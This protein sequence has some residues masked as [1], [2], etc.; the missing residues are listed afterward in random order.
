MRYLFVIGIALLMGGT[1]FA[2]TGRDT[3]PD[4]VAKALENISA[5]CGSTGRNEACYGHFSLD[6]E[7]QPSASTFN[8]DAPGDIESVTAIRTLKLAGVDLSAGIWGVALM[9]LQANLPDTSPGQNVTVLLFGDVELTSNDTMMTGFYLQ[10]GIG[11]SACR[12]LPNSGIMVQTPKGSTKIALTVNDVLIELGS[13]VYIT[14][15]ESDKMSVYL[16][17]GEALVTAEG[18][19]VSLE[20][21]YY[22][23][24]LLGSSLTPSSVPRPA[25][26]YEAT[27]LESLSMIG[28]ALPRPLIE[29][30]DICTIE[31]SRSVNMRSGPSTA[32]DVIGALNTGSSYEV[33]HF[34]LLDGNKWWQVTGGG[35]V[36]A[37]LVTQTG[38]C[39]TVTSTIDYPPVPVDGVTDSVAEPDSSSTS[40]APSSSGGSSSVSGGGSAII[41]PWGCE[42][43][44]SEFTPGT[45]T[46]FYGAGGYDSC[47]EAQA[48][49]SGSLANF[50]GNGPA[51]FIYRES[52]CHFA[53][54]KWGITT[55]AE[56]EFL[57]GTYSYVADWIHGARTCSFTVK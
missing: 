20:P 50:V 6:A 48:A 53:Y 33:A 45:I 32:Y 27:V 36:L 34:T 23:E 15:A 9:Q 31:V 47:E 26:A 11:D 3:C 30:S 2:Q 29:I 5:L 46:L 56:G 7:A 8:F 21:G 52:D 42:L 12:E 19:T 39:D 13:T 35:W 25:E 49:T 14:V 38:D 4:V 43:N 17:E 16:L 18:E 57:S 51:L 10:S 37:R 54:E 40:S 41:H 22:T 28:G 24:I 44:P 55:V 1:L